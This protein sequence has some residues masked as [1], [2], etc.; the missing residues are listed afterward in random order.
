MSRI[1]RLKLLKNVPFEKDTN[2]ILTFKSRDEQNLFFELRAVKSF[3]NLSFVKGFF[4][5][6]VKLDVD[7]E[8]VKDCNYLMFNNDGDD[9]FYFAYITNF[10]YISDNCVEVS[11]DLDYFQTYMGDIQFM[12]SSIIRE[13]TKDDE[14]FNFDLYFDD[15]EV[16]VD[17]YY[18]IDKQE[19]TIKEWC[20]AIYYRQNLLI[21]SIFND[22]S[23]WTNTDNGGILG[24]GKQQINY[25]KDYT[26]IWGGSPVA[27]PN[28]LYS[29]C[30]ILLLPIT[31]SDEL[32]RVHTI[33]TEMVTTGYK[34]INVCMIPKK[35]YSN[36]RKYPSTLVTR[37]TL[38]LKDSMKNPIYKR[39]NLVYNPVNNKCFTYPYCYLEASNKQGEKK[40]YRY[41]KCLG[42]EDKL[43]DIVFAIIEDLTNSYKITAI[44]YAYNYEIGIRGIMPYQESIEY[45]SDYGISTKLNTDTS[46]NEDANTLKSLAGIVVGIGATVAGG[47]TGNI[48]VAGAGLETIKKNALSSA[49]AITNPHEN[50]SVSNLSIGTIIANDLFGITFTQ[51]ICEYEDLEAID[52]YFSIYGYYYKGIKKRPNVFGRKRF[53]YVRLDHPRIMG[54]IPIECRKYVIEK[55]QDGVTFWHDT[56]NF[57]YGDFR[58]NIIVDEDLTSGGKIFD[59]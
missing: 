5:K 25:K 11:F 49:N 31:T 26:D 52:N 39:E 20:V 45:S 59:E 42:Y 2:T 51:Y 23:T 14:F 12:E 50:N 8:I 3:N 35:Y 33:L 10:E 7:I 37:K 32:K 43:G 55:L 18:M 46:W 15:P 47:V 6:K 4:Y 58:Q 29:G 34:V 48:A 28:T 36:D 27:I 30:N 24:S 38:K 41:E 53:N 57:E 9:R 40:I 1:S 44:P 54:N 19:Y 13:H 56:Q 16:A 22:Q 21:E 17:K